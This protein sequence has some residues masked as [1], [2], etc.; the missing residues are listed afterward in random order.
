MHV[1]LR[2]DTVTQ[3]TA[4][5]RQAMA[6]AAVGDD[7]YGEDPTV[8]ALESE[9]AQLLGKPAAMFT[10][11]G[12]MANGIGLQL[13]APP[14]EEVLADSEA[15]VVSHELGAAAAIGGISTRTWPAGDGQL[16]VDVVA[17]TI[18]PPGFHAVATRAV[19]VENTHNRGGGT[20]VALEALKQLRALADARD[21]ALHCDGARLW[22]AHVADG[23][24]LHEYGALFDTVSVCLSKGLGAPVGSVLAASVERIARARVLRKRMGGGMRQVGILAAAGRHALHNHLDR[25]ADDH[26]RAMRLAAALDPFGVVDVARVRTNIVALHVPDAP[27]FASEAKAQGVLVS[28]TGPDTARLLTHLDVDDAG[29]DRAIAV[30]TGLLRRR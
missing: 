9:V 15:H 23:V 14:G 17:D 20:V 19:S 13:L 28:A 1:D 5:M 4:A 8:N 6:D 3:P 26:T 21:V 18:R 16:D 7:V 27:G 24:G 29:V 30:L 10:P 12:S 11:T 25:L 22:N 2:S